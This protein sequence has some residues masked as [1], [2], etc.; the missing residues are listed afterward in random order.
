MTPAVPSGLR[1]PGEEID[2]RSKRGDALIAVR[3]LSGRE[4]VPEPEEKDGE[5][6]RDGDDDVDGATIG[7]TYSKFGS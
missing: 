2:L 6:R 5:P 7:H 1:A 4:I 3:I